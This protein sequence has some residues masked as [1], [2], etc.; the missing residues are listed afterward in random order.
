MN[1]KDL[2]ESFFSIDNIKPSEG[3]VFDEKSYDSVMDEY[4]EKIIRKAYSLYPS[5][6]KLAEA[7]K[8]SQS[9]AN[10]LIKKHIK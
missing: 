5:S 4:E 2:P 10:R 7:L 1:V 8:I 6:R 9:T 3:C